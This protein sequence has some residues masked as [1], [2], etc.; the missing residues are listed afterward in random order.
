MFSR[1]F[2]QYTKAGYTRNPMPAQPQ[3][4]VVNASFRMWREFGSKKAA[5]ILGRRPV[6]RVRIESSLMLHAAHRHSAQALSAETADCLAFSNPS[7]SSGNQIRPTLASGFAPR[8]A[9]VQTLS[10]PSC[11]IKW[12][13]ATHIFHPRFML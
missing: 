13:C 8:C 6:S 10:A 3:A 12:K 11:E 7:T 2:S 9:R 5:A 1:V 4:G